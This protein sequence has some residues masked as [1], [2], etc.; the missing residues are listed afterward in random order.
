MGRRAITRCA[1]ARTIAVSS[2]ATGICPGAHFVIL[3]FSTPRNLVVRTAYHAYFHHLLPLI[4][5]LISGHRTAYRYL[6]QSVS[7]F[8]VQEALAARMSAAG[9]HDVRWTDL[10]FGIAA[11]HTG[12]K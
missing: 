5:G 8:P 3:E 9:F 6:P 7:N 2:G 10:A 1:A 12:R 4:G 11:I